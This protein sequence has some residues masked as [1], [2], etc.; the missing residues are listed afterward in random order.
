VFLRKAKTMPI[1][2][3]GFCPPLSAENAYFPN[4][5][6]ISKIGLN[7]RFEPILLMRGREITGVASA[8]HCKF[9][10]LF[11]GRSWK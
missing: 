8:P 9:G 7:T 2:G 5:L 3:R 10:L 4:A 11:K 1:G 6:H